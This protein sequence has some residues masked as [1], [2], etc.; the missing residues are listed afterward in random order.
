MSIRLVG[1]DQPELDEGLS[2]QGAWFPVGSGLGEIRVRPISN[3]DFTRYRKARM[4]PYERQVEAG[5]LDNTIA[6]KILADSLAR[7]ILTDW[8]DLAYDDKGKEIAYS[9]EQGV[10]AMTP[11]EGESEEEKRVR[12]T[13]IA[14]V[15]DSARNQAAFQKAKDDEAAEALGK[16]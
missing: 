14:W 15:V 4:E 13:F 5:I 10:K 2:K 6:E 12:L 8:R 11:R 16:D 3:P 7:H 1:F 9:V